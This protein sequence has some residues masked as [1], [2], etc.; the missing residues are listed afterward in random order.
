MG[1]YV[2]RFSNFGQT[3]ESE[4]KTPY[5]ACRLSRLAKRADFPLVKAVRRVR[6]PVRVPVAP[7]QAP[8][9]GL[10]R[11]PGPSVERLCLVAEFV[12]PVGIDR[13]LAGLI[14]A[15]RF[16]SLGGRLAQP[17]EARRWTA[18]SK[19]LR[20]LPRNASTPRWAVGVMLT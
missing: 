15:G 7:R 9:A 4:L 2:S 8:S 12:E 6:V 18:A 1:I 19:D 11:P 16:R 17:S 3:P 20:A 5:D 10:S 13:R 14:A